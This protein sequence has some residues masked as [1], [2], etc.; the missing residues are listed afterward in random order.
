MQQL[1]SLSG[2]SNAEI[3]RAT[4]HWDLEFRWRGRAAADLEQV[5][6]DIDHKIDQVIMKHSQEHK[7]CCVGKGQGKAVGV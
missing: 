3:L 2:K 4:L 5:H 1:E 7:Q 6:R